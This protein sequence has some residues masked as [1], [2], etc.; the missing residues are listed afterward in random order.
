MISRDVVIMIMLMITLM[1]IDGC[2]IER[3]SAAGCLK[4]A[5]DFMQHHSERGCLLLPKDT[6]VIS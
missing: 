5:M 2:F 4:P 6:V 3:D 1:I